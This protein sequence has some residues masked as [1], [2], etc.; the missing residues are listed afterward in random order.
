MSEQQTEETRK[1]QRA[2]TAGPRQDPRTKRWSF[3]VDGGTDPR[4]GRRRQIRRRGF[5]TKKAA[6]S[7]LTRLRGSLQNGTFVAPENLTLGA[8]IVDD[9]LPAIRTTVEPSTLESYGR[10]LRLHVIAHIGH[11]PVQRLEPQHL[12]ALYAD[13][14]AGGRRDGK[15]GGLKART[16][17]YL[18][19]ILHRALKD[20][21]K[22]GKVARNVAELADP[23]SA[24]AA[25]APE[26]KVW[27][28]AELRA[29]LNHLEQSDDRL[30]CAFR[31]AGMAGLRRGEILG[32]TWDDLDSTQGSRPCGASCV[33]SVDSSS[34]SRSQRPQR[35]G[36]ASASTRG[37]LP[38]FGASALVRRPSASASARATARPAWC[39]RS[40]TG[41]RSIHCR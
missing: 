38:S 39:S 35:A 33:V 21:A 22:W 40:T 17:R 8:F 29:F 28:P 5:P 9:W 15:P 26:M 2:S 27:S 14:L 24:K 19:T 3:V 4:T 32:L 18:H 20:A 23:P 25:R 16:V 12:N 37:R 30:A 6:E 7:E 31:L 11:V 41:R 36:D 13:L 1:R 10:M 34:T